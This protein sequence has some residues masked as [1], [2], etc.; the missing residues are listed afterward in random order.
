MRRDGVARA[1]DVPLPSD[2]RLQA[3]PG[4]AM[5]AADRVVVGGSPLRMLRLSAAGMAV[6]ER[7]VAGSSVGAAGPGA[8][9][10]ARRLVA[11]GLAH[12]LPP[13]GGGRPLTD[14][15]IAVPVRDRAGDL[16]VLLEA[17]SRAGTSSGTSTS[18]GIS[19]SSGTSAAVHEVLVVDDGSVDGSGDV[20]RAAGARVVR[21][22]VPGGPGAARRTALR[23]ATTPVVAF[24]DSDVIPA[25][26]WLE[27]VLAHLADPSVAAVAPRVASRP[28]PSLRE[29]Y[30]H[31][32][33]P[34]DMGTRPGAARPGGRLSYVPAAALV[35]RREIGGGPVDIDPG[36]RYG[37]D[38]DLVWRLADAG[39]VVRYEP[40]AT[41]THRPRGSWPAWAAQR[42][43]YGSS[44]AALAR[45]HPA[46]LRPLAGTGTTLATWALAA[47]GQPALAAALAGLT[48]GRLARR[49]AGNGGGAGT[50]STGGTGARGP[51]IAASIVARGHLHTAHAVA[52][53]VRRCWLPL[54]PLALA[55]GPRGRTALLAVIVVPAVRDWRR[56]RP[57]IGLVTYAALRLA[58]DAAYCAGVWRGCLAER[59]A[60]P[61][62]PAAPRL[63]DVRLARPWLS[64]RS[65]IR[66]RV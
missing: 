13:P 9:T 57:D 1:V 37:E 36:L 55:A 15:T 43:G 53:T 61:L 27:L 19:T 51:L 35:L 64:S 30:E 39:W 60:A 40:A 63:P 48:I 4:L 38:V 12:P 62:L 22:D 8:G 50:G 31:A 65:R 18:S 33:S 44:A 17:L 16:A 34:I 25:A 7:L 42:V 11:G 2:F 29:R 6:V 28:G 56:E 10:I 24:L 14:V 47:A 26:G 3:D 21:H 20:A 49:F 52:D 66:S 59:T 45:R 46:P 54:V 58:D 32:R 41:V 23:A 5:F